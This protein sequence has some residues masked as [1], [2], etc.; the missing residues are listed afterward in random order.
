MGKPN[1]HGVKYFL[2]RLVESIKTP[3][4]VS[5]IHNELKSMGFRIGKNTVYDYLYYAESVY[6]SFTAYKYGRS[7]KR[8]QLAEKKSYIIDNGFLTAL[9]HGSD[10]GKKLENLVAIELKRRNHD[11]FFAKNGK[12]C[13]F[14][15][16]EN[17]LPIQVCADISSPQTFDREI[18]G[19]VFGARL[20]GS[21][22]A[23]IITPG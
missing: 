6:F 19:A 20:L 16:A 10:Y 23:L 4:S 3:V 14:I 2:K 9:T 7:I 8:R 15:V 11:L 13:D 18:Q 22:D 17:N 12:E 1:I 5:K 21:Q